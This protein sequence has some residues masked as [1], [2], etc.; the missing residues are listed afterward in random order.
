MHMH[1]SCQLSGVPGSCW[2]LDPRPPTITSPVTTSPMTSVQPSSYH[3]PTAHPPS[4]PTTSASA[5]PTVLS[6]FNIMT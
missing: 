2:S 3:R 4:L 1:Y 5:A 6:E